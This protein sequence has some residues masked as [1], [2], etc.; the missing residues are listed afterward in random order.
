MTLHQ[1]QRNWDWTRL[2][3]LEHVQQLNT[4][5]ENFPTKLNFDL[6]NCLVVYNQPDVN[7]ALFEYNAYNNMINSSSINNGQLFAP[8]LF[9]F[10]SKDLMDNPDTIEQDDALVSMGAVVGALATTAHNLGYHTGFCSCLNVKRIVANSDCSTVIEFFSQ[11][12][13]T[14]LAVAVGIG[15]AQ[16]HLNRG[17]VVDLNNTQLKTVPPK[18]VLQKNITRIGC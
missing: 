15:H 10:N 1:T 9:V 6:Y 8:L 3:T 17:T 13:S 16:S 7:S 14:N 11:P 5:L 12:N 4:L 18:P 2:P